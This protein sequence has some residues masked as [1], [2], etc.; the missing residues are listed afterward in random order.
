[1][2]RTVAMF[3]GQGLF[4]GEVS[5]QELARELPHLLD[6]CEELLGLDPF[7]LRE[8]PTSVAQPVIYCASLARWRRGVDCVEV[9][10]GHS[11]GEITALAAAGAMAPE[12]GLEAVVRRGRLTEEV[13]AGTG[14]GML[15]VGVPI[16]V[17]EELAD[18]VGAVVANDN[19]P[20]QVV[21]SGPNAALER[22]AAIAVERNWRRFRLPVP[23]AFHSAWMDPAVEPFRAVL[24]G[25][26]FEEPRVPVVSCITREPIEDPVE[27]LSRA[28]VSRVRWR[29]LLLDLHARGVDRFHDIGPGDM[30][31]KLARLTLAG[32]GRPAEAVQ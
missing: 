2:P 24:R 15:A 26:R 12:D 30:L 21:L 5:R 9:V 28:L 18:E 10:A 16:E 17:G 4:P 25:I 7:E 29:E 8:W 27:D 23:G 32:A 14:T 31:R 20:Q 6:R 13:A 19:S 1:M 3:P 11:M 22:A